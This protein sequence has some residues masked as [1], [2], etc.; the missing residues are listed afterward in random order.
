MK[1]F[2]VSV[3]CTV[4]FLMVSSVALAQG[5]G[6]GASKPKVSTGSA[7]SGSVSHGGGKTA[8]VTTATGPRTSAQGGAKA[9]GPTLK[10]STTT[11]K[12]TGP[13]TKSTTT[14]KATGPKTKST[15]TTAKATGPKTKSTTTAKATGPKT[16][17][18][19]TTVKETGPKTKSTT[20]T[21]T[22]STSTGKSK[23]ETTTTASTSTDTSKKDTTTTVATGETL[24]A[25]QQKLQR[26]TNLAKKLE[27]R[28]P[29]GTDL[30]EAAKD[31]SN[32]GKF[33][34]AVNVSFNHDLDFD[35]LKTAMIDDGM[36]LGQ[37]MKDQRTSLDSGAEAARAQRE[38]E[39]MIRSSEPELTTSSTS[40]T[41]T[42]TTRKPATAKPKDRQ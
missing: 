7:K 21:T 5:K 16:K 37:A 8:H 25:V 26:N 35:K 30:M 20:T 39:V 31:F 34:A 23:K 17:S 2:I 29:P 22:A 24:S 28:L 33:V 11:V 18:T 9:H 1:K 14:A 6:G 19:T 36:S 15:T 12:A 27:S 40:S 4:A 3:G 13:K 32:L 42:T 38:A 10:Q 41:T